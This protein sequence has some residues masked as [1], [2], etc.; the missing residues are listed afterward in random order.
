M[1]GENIVEYDQKQ[2][3]KFRPEDGH[4]FQH[5]G[6]FTHRTIQANVE[7]GLEV[8]KYLRRKSKIAKE[9][10]ESWD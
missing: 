6:L 2:L 4:G 9:A 8:R 1:D 3:R 10:I 7:Y 5:F